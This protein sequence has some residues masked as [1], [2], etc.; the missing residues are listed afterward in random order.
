MKLNRNSEEKMGELLQIIESL[1]LKLMK[2]GIDKGLNDPKT[3]Q[4]SEQLDVYIVRYQ[5]LAAAD[6]SNY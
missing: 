5:R 6:K 3:L 4:I 2:S 1:K